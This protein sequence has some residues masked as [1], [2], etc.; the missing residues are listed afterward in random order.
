MYKVTRF[1]V[2]PDDPN[3]DSGM[4]IGGETA[5]ISDWPLNPEGQPLLHL[6]SIN[7]NTLS[8]QVH[9]PSLPQDKYISVFSTYSASEY[10]LDQVTYTGDELEWN[11]NIV[12]GCTYVSVSSHPLTSVCP[13]PPIPLSGVHLIEMELDDHEFPAFS[14]FSPTVT[15]CVKGID[16]LLEE[17]Q[18]VCQI[19]SGDF[20]EPYRDILGLPD[21]NG[22]LFLRSGPAS[23]HAPFDG[24]FFVQTA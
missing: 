12:A 6:F 1:T 16:H 2:D 18:L 10:F 9:I 14:F 13:V 23:A 20:P 19:Y 4:W 11:E 15:N 8:Q 17:H 21:A 7:C 22:Y 5:Y 3:Q 24:I